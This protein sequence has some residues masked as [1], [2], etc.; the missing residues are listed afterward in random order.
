MNE[1]NVKVGEFSHSLRKN[2]FMEHFGL[3]DFE[4]QDPLNENLLK[5]I[6]Q[7]AKVFIKILFLI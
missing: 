7:I 1:K 3:N 5:K 6:T 2:L 4:V